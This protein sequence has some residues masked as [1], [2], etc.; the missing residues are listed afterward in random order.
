MK[1]NVTVYCMVSEC[2]YNMEG[3]CTRSE[4]TLY[5]LEHTYK[6]GGCDEGYELYDEEKEIKDESE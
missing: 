3:M 5:D 4:I 1:P 2:K 6:S